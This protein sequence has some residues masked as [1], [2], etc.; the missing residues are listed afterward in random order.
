MEFIPGSHLEGIKVH[1]NVS[2][3][4]E[5]R[6]ALAVSADSSR[7]VKITRSIGDVSFHHCRTLHFTNGNVADTPRPE[8]Y[9]CN[10]LLSSLGLRAKTTGFS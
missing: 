3:K 5:I 10:F 1:N 8:P 9:S 6:D 4:S 7:A 2:H